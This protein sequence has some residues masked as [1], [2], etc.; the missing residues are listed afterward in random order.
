MSS[1]A[2][3]SSGSGQP[4]SYIEVD[5]VAKRYRA[6][7]ST[8]VDAIREVNLS[9]DK[10]EFVS[11][12]GPSG[13]GKSTLLKIIGRL[14]APSSGSITY[15]DGGAP[16]ERPRIGM[17]FQDAVLLPWRTVMDNVM[18]PV[19]VAGV[20]MEV[21]RQ[22]ALDLLALVG[23]AGFGDKY[24]HELSGG[25][26]QRA[27][28]SRALVTDPGLLLMDEPFGALDALTREHMGLELQ[29]IWSESRKT[30]IFVTHSISEAVFLS[31]RVIVMSDRPSTIS[32]DVRIDLPRPRTFE[33]MATPQFGTQVTEIRNKLLAKTEF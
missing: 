8:P 18:L 4:R 9:I 12:V 7:H 2:A 23:L 17:V 32:M 28:I 26:Q 15:Y 10:G 5:R 19:E 25:M 1:S 16:I 20:D 13:C 29:R 14:T 33:M 27:S 22:R 11:I 3:P 30:V 21:G 31:D 6:Q 24:P